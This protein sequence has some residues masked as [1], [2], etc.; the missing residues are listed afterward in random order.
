VAL[1]DGRDRIGGFIAS[2]EPALPGYVNDTYSSWHPLFL[3]GPAYGALGEALHAPG[4][5]Y[6]NTDG[7]VTASVSERGTVVADRDAESTFAGFEKAADRAAYQQMLAELDDRSASV[8][9]VL[10]SSLSGSR[11]GGLGAGSGHLVAQQLLF[12]SRVRAGARRLLERL[13]S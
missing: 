12:T 8:F 11:L 10:G 5:E 9:G 3:A 6:C 13:P 4:L 2:D 1:I 7:A